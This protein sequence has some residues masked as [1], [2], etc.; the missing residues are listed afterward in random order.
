M[1][2][3]RLG[4]MNTISMLLTSLNNDPQPPRG[5]TRKRT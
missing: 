1:G 2:M 5:D 4:L 3:T